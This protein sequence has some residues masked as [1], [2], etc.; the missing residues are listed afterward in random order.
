MNAVCRKFVAPALALFVAAAVVRAQRGSGMHAG[1]AL[2]KDTVAPWRGNAEVAGKIT[3]E[4]GK[5]L[6]NVKVTF[7]LASANQGFFATTKKNGE[8]SAK[9]IKAGEWR[10]LIEAADFVTVRQALTI[11]DGRNPPLQVQLKRDTS[12]ELLTA[13]DALFKAGK[14]ADARAEYMKVLAA[15]PDLAGI[16]RAIAFTYGREGNHAEA[17]KYLDL[18]LAGNRSDTQLLQLAAASATQ[19]NDFPRAMAYLAAIDDGALADPDPLQTAAIN[20]LNKRRSGDAIAVLDRIV[21][22]WPQY[23]DA[24]FYRGLAKLQAD[25]NAEGR[26]DL[27]KF[28]AIAPA[29][30]PQMAQAREL[31]SRIK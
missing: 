27:E 17:L 16:N 7:V 8:F 30:A 6:A 14:L 19:V 22:R 12:S 11:A 10:V 31:L 26:A 15:H 25:R 23:A 29:D 1:D 13:A 20:L 9:D 4:A 3:D 2:K 18:A 28:V 5:G 24:F 21:A